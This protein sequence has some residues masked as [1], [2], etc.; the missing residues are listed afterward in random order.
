[1]KFFLLISALVA[2]APV[3]ARGDVAEIEIPAHVEWCTTVHVAD[4][5]QVNTPEARQAVSNEGGKPIA[6]CARTNANFL[7]RI[8]ITSLSASAPLSKDG[9]EMQLTFC[10]GIASIS[11]D[12]PACDGVVVR[13]VAAQKAIFAVC[14][15]ETAESS[16]QGK[17]K[18]S[19]HGAPWNLDDTQLQALSWRFE[20]VTNAGSSA[21]AIVALLTFGAAQSTTPA[22]STA[23][24][25]KPVPV[26]IALLPTA[27]AP[28]PP[29]PAPTSPA[30]APHQDPAASRRR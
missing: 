29:T 13:Q 26:I 27:P 1:M 18:E 6:D 25:E 9:K 22:G 12:P 10:A 21:D 19:L 14:P 16:C 8:G 30:P 15:E 3:P 11:N 24:P 20:Q 28:V 7:S 4:V 23:A 5:T 17:M 2:L